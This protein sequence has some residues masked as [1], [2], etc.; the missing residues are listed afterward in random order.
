MVTK[1][2]EQPPLPALPLCDGCG[3]PPHVNSEGRRLPLKRCTRCRLAAYHGVECQRRHYPQHRPLCR[4]QAAA[5]PSLPIVEV[6]VE[7]SARDDRKGKCVVVTQDCRHPNQLLAAPFLDPM[8]PPVL[9]SC[10]RLS[11]CAVCFQKL[12]LQTSKKT[13]L[14]WLCKH[15]KYPVVVCSEECRIASRDWLPQEVQ[16]VTDTLMV[17]YSAR[18]DV[19]I[20]PTAILI[21]RLFLAAFVGDE[22]AAA[23]PDDEHPQS[24]PKVVLDWERDVMAMQTHQPADDDNASEALLHLQAVL[25]LVTQI[26]TKSPL[27][28]FARI[29]SL[30]RQCDTPSRAVFEVLNRIKVNAFTVT[31]EHDARDDNQHP[32]AL[33]VALYPA[34]AFRI[35]HSCCPNARQNFVLARGAPPRLQIRTTNCGGEQKGMLLLAAGDEVCISYTDQLQAST[36]KRRAALLRDYH[37]HCACPR[38][39]AGE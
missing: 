18:P 38:C 34:P 7:P 27:W 23:V 21:C 20:L 35:N 17:C 2:N 22:A 33:G 30:E 19:Q 4:R 13:T 15:P 24:S 10:N 12:P 31:A 16:A 39:E 29:Q 25:M 14:C 28:S 6:R 1:E 26:L 32:Q 3:K 37:F 36:E 5:P 9:F 11:H 8:V